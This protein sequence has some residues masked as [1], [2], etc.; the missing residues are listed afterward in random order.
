MA[1]K[2]KLIAE[3]PDTLED[4]EILEEQNNLKG[5]STL[6]VR[7]PY[8][9][10]NL[11]NRNGRYYEKSSTAKEVDRYIK[12]M[13]APGRAMGELN[14]PSSADVNLERASH[15]VMEL[16]EDGDSYIG[17]SKVLSTPCGQILRSLI[18]DG[19]KVG[20]STRALGSLQE[21]A[22][23]NVVQN[24]H[25]VAIDAVADPSYPK[26]FVN[27]ILESKTF[28]IDDDGSYEEL[29]DNFEKNIKQLPKRDVDKYLR[30]QVIK[31]IN[32]LH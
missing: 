30:E 10:C 7:G 25:L 21:T 23:Y 32:N 16:V 2:L 31:F 22:D 27:G 14:H 20:M 24:M 11:K 9:G 4:F 12:E 6:Y 18:N 29:Y 1:L 15:L 19:V 3:K 17:K 13:V 5:Q 8:I 28:I 26:A